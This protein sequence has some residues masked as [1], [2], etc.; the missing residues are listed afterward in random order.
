VKPKQ[1][2]ALRK[3]IT[4]NLVSHHAR[5]MGKFVINTGEGSRTS[6]HE[7]G[8]RAALGVVELVSGL[9]ISFSSSTVGF[10]EG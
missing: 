9:L 6:G 1:T 2:H 8:L 10:I 3:S 5:M 7:L 4:K